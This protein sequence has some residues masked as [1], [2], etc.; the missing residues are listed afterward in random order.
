[1][2]NASLFITTRTIIY[3][4]IE[5]FEFFGRRTDGRLLD[6]IYF[7]SVF[8]PHLCLPLRF[9]HCNG[10][11]RFYNIH[12]FY[13]WPSTT[14][15]LCLY[16]YMLCVQCSVCYSV[17]YGSAYSF[18]RLVTHCTH[19][20]HRYLMQYFYPSAAPQSLSRCQQRLRRPGINWA[21]CII[22]INLYV[23]IYIRIRRRQVVHPFSINR[24]VV[25]VL[26]REGR[27]GYSLD[28]VIRTRIISRVRTAKH[29]LFYCVFSRP[30][31]IIY[32]F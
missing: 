11:E 29:V 1:M 6:I 9:A 22:H 19:I 27:Q 16:Y 2:L 28:V 15:Q 18:T 26:E 21:D 10:P 13:P 31:R 12:S 17:V 23:Y 24:P 8:Y 7:T 20:G 30:P 3:C 32:D 5:K 14:T 4:R 25:V